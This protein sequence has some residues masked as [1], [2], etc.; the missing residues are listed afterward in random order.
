MSV[1]NEH[2]LRRS[3]NRMAKVSDSEPSTRDTRNLYKK[4]GIFLF[5]LSG[6]I[7]IYRVT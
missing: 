6:K 3:R 5:Y 2:L 4:D 1:A 7:R